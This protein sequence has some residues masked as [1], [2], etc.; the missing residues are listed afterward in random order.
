MLTVAATP[1]ST[2]ATPVSGSPRAGVGGVQG[3]IG[4][5]IRASAAGFQTSTNGNAITVDKAA[6]VPFEGVMTATGVLK[7]KTAHIKGLSKAT[8]LINTVAGYGMLILTA[9]VSGS[10]R[11]PGNTV[12]DLGGR[13]ADLIDGKKTATGWHVG[14]GLAADGSR[15]PPTSAVGDALDA[16]GMK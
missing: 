7:E 10:V 12:V 1:T 14:W 9:N 15:V 8:G 5:L 16:L 3:A 13:L 2:P 6:I 11:S 4:D